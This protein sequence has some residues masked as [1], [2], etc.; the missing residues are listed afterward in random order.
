VACKPTSHI[1]ERLVRNRAWGGNYLPDF[2]PRPDGTMQP[3]YY[4]ACDEM[5][6]WM[7]Y[8]AVSVFDVEAGPYPER[9]DAPVTVKDI[10][11]YVHFLSRQKPTATLTG[12][13]TPKAATVLRTGQ[14]ATW[15]E[16]GGRVVLALPAE[17][18]TDLD[19]VLEVTW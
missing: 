8:G 19:E 7:K 15:K 3:A 14:A 1:I 2:G 18:P 10:V 13:H 17:P 9:C 6:E 16:E 4:A 12:V 5:A 11:W